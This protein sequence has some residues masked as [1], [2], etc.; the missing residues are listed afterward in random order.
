[1][2]NLEINETAL[3]SWKPNDIEGVVSS[4]AATTFQFSCLWEFNLEN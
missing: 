2:S 4:P 3:D 1:V